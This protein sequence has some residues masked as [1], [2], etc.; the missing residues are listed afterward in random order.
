MGDTVVVACFD[1][2]D[3]DDDDD[4]DD[5]ERNSPKVTDA[6]HIKAGHDSTHA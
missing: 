4:D 5:T 6:L 2:V 1:I 3:D